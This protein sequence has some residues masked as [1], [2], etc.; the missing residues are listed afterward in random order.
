MTL[1]RLDSYSYGLVIYPECSQEKWKEA[2]W[3]RECASLWCLL[4]GYDKSLEVPLSQEISWKRKSA[5]LWCLLNGLWYI[6][7]NGPLAKRPLGSMKVPHYGAFCRVMINHWK[8]SF[9]K[10]ASWDRKYASL[11]CLLIGFS[12][13]GEFTTKQPDPELI[14]LSR[15]NAQEF[16]KYCEFTIGFAGA[17][18]GGPNNNHY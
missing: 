15:P 12:L 3:E 4:M 13:Q 5:S 7:E 10:N 18:L 9:S 8:L 14:V 6:I 2:S 17:R 16:Q 1:P 11:W